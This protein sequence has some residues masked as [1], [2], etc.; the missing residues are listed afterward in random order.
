MAFTYSDQAVSFLAG[1]DI[2]AGTA[3]KFHNDG[4]IPCSVAGEHSVGIC[5]GGLSGQPVA[6]VI[7][8]IT[9]ARFAA[10]L[11][12]GTMVTTDN[13]GNIVAANSS[14]SVIGEVAYAAGANEIGS[15]LVDK[16]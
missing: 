15:I 5:R 4:V 1:D 7:G 14:D 13:K 12:T 2:P 6:V 8:G 11:T 3:V 9:K 10:A 16:L